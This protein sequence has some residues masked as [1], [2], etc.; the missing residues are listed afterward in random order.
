MAFRC[1]SELIT[2]PTFQERFEYL[3]LGGTIGEQTF[4]TYGRRWMNQQFYRSNEWRDIKTEVILRD[5]VCD[6]AIPEYEL[7]DS[8]RIYVH[9]MKPLTDEDIFRR[10]CYLLDPEYLIT[11][12]HETHNAIHYGDINVSRM[13]RDIVVRTPNDTCPWIHN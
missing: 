5:N 11:T 8:T 12:S 1:Y 4:G 10:T 9:H 13:A 2:L 3:K 6:L 7:P